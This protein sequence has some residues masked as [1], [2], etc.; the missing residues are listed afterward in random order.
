L[1]TTV[2]KMTNHCSPR[3]GWIV[4]YELTGGPQAIF[5]PSGSTAVEVPTDA[6]GKASVE[7]VQKD[8]SPGTSQI[9]VQ[10]F[11]PADQSSPQFLVRQGCT[12]VSWNDQASATAVPT[13]AAPTLPGP[14]SASPPIVTPPATGAPTS[15]PPPTGGT[16]SVPEASPAPVVASVLQLEI[17]RPSLAVVGS[18]VTFGIAITNRGTT[19]AR[20]VIVRD[21]FDPGLEPL[22]SRPGVDPHSTAPMGFKVGDLRPGETL[23][24]SVTFRVTKP[25]Q[26]CHRMEVVAADG[27]RAEQS[28]CVT[29]VAP[30]ITNPN[31]PS[32]TYPGTNTAPPA[33]AT[34][35]PELRVTAQAATVTVG[36]SVVFTAVISNPSQQALPNV[37]IRQQSDAAL[38]VTNITP[39]GSREGN[40]LVWSLPPLPTGRDVAVVRVECKCLHAAAKACCRFTVESAS[41]RPV[42]EQACI[43]ITAAN[44]PP[45]NPLPTNPLPSGTGIRPPAAASSRLVVS[46]G[47]RNTVHAGGNQQFV[48]TV[49]ND[50]DAAENDIVVTAKL[51]AGS[52]LV[53]AESDPSVMFRQQ[54]DVVSFGRIAEL[55]PG[56]SASLRVT[57]TTS[58]QGPISL[59]AA[60]TSVRHPQPVPGSAT[61]EVLQ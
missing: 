42:S 59:E 12:A 24:R 20:E 28:S 29:A 19:V 16:R 23:R 46:V 47:N 13:P 4:R 27:G 37:R 34:V 48:V 39:G 36:Q 56:K 21:T 30:A 55:P 10:L 40:E 53:R 1:T 33:A 7:I 54:A 8:P 22:S 31:P 2:W 15:T 11:R 38:A 3:A 57:V 51:P 61:V 50:G 58:K 60:A 35:P 44:P 26:L 41:I 43:E 18:N 32:A 9:R 49:G 6:A 17:T 25:G 45:M 5:V 14:A 52:T